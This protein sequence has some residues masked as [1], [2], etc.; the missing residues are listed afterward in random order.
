MDVRIP[1][2][3]LPR[4]AW[5]GYI[6]HV[7]PAGREVERQ[8]GDVGQAIVHDERSRATVAEKRGAPV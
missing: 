8:S 6:E 4:R 1:N 5:V 7:Q 2:P 3:Y